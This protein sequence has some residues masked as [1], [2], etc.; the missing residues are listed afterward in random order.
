[1]HSAMYTCM[2]MYIVY[3]CNHGIVT[4]SWVSANPEV[5]I[6]IKFWLIIEVSLEDNVAVTHVQ[7]A[8]ESYKQK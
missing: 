3:V 5:D 7:L 1:M 2:Y 8:K 6:P 4:H